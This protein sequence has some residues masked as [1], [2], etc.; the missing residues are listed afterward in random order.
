MVHLPYICVCSFTG[1]AYL[2]YRRVLRVDG[3]MRTRV[4]GDGSKLIISTTDGFMVVIHDLNLDRITKDLFG[5]VPSNALI[6]LRG[7]ATAD[8]PGE[9]PF[10]YLFTAKRNRVEI[11]TDFPMDDEPSMIPSLEVCSYWLV[12]CRIRNRKID[13]NNCKIKAISVDVGLCGA[14]GRCRISPPRLA[15]C[16]K[17]R[18]NQGSFV[19]A[20]CLIV[21]FL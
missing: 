10:E 6:P 11:I 9:D 7:I 21:C 1:D 13:E 5:F 8:P 16:R 2:I 12:M 18:L 14:W 17:R 15:E 19:S 3:L 20:V 4:T